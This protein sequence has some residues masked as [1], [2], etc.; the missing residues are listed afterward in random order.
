[1]RIAI[2]TEAVLGILERCEAGEWEL[3][4]SEMVETEVAQI[5]DQERRQRI[6]SAVG[7][8]RSRVMVDDRVENRGNELQSFGFQGF[9]AIHVACAEMAQAD[10]FLSTD[11]RLLKRAVRYRERLDVMVNNPALWFIARVQAG[12][13][14]DDP[15]GA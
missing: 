2:E 15:N 12:G 8:A 4:G 7:M 5:V 1:L 10:V 13:S 9:D 14:E 3:I 11:D 6:E